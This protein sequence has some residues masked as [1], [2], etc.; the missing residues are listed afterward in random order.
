MS[1]TCVSQFVGGAAPNYG[2]HI[3]FGGFQFARVVS[4]FKLLKEDDAVF[5]WRERLLDAYG[6]VARN[7]PGYP[8]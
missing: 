7:A 6:G 3:I 1:F 8:V 5:A 4:P 2:D